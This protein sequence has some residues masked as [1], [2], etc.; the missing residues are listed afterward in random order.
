[1]EGR[2]EGLRVGQM[3]A[4]IDAALDAL[5]GDRLRLA[6]D[7]ERL[8]VLRAAVRVEARLHAWVAS[9]A[10][11]LEADQVVWRAHGTST[12]T[13][14][15][16][17]VNLTHR[18]ASR[19]ITSG[20]R[21]ARL[22]VVGAAALAGDVLPGQA[23]AI[24]EVLDRV[25]DELPGEELV[26]AQELMVGFAATHTSTEL[27]RLAGRLLEVVAPEVAEVS[28][29]KR[30]EREHR[31]AMRARFLTFTPDHHG[32]VLIRGS[33][34]VVDAE[35]L[36]RI[37]GAYA[38]AQRGLDVL[39]PA[40][41]YVTPAM[42]RADGLLAMVAHHAQGA[43]APSSGGDRPRIVITLSYDKLAK[44]AIDAGLLSPLGRTAVSTPAPA[45]SPGLAGR[46][47]GTDEPV[48]A[49]VLR[50]LL[51]DADLL[52]VV[53]GGASQVLDV[54]RTQRLVTPAIRA[55]LEVRDA[56]CVFPGCD[57][58]P[59]ACHAHHLTPWWNGG[60]TSL[61]NLVLVCPHHHGIVEP[62]HDPT[63]DRWQLRLRPDGV[64]E[65]LPPVR[66]DPVRR[67][68]VH[69]RFRS[70]AG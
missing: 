66:V 21:Q 1:M 3:L 15:A 16:Q 58:P 38:S 55:A 24:G 37:V 10:A 5:G 40:A 11:G 36:V 41:G 19:M 50:R 53:L 48:A 25:G 8:E 62:G 4:V 42:R 65:V 27:R 34:P 18:E 22:P 70:R 20:E 12:S 9:L 43:L 2:F 46:L 26:R 23:E 13:W 64:P 35:P 69:A 30:L 32:S 47:V 17:A 61:A 59:A 31:Q 29:A 52:P 6:D 14:L 33:L 28:E 49:S 7:A 54:G 67:P 56:G 68:R 57:K 63:A 45:G 44:T 39:D 60:A 51:C